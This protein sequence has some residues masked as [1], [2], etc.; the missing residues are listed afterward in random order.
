ML[1]RVLNTNT[2]L[3]ISGEA[4]SRKAGLYILPQ[5][6]NTQH[7]LSILPEQV[8]CTVLYRQSSE[9]PSVGK[10]VKTLS[11]HHLIRGH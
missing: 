8:D 11:Q 1:Y 9:E 7:C 3:G 10:T 4:E 6:S 2:Y 5:F